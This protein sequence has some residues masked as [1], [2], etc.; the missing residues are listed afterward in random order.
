MRASNWR[1]VMFMVAVSRDGSRQRGN[2][3]NESEHL[4]EADSAGWDEQKEKEEEEG[5]AEKKTRNPMIE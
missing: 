3:S 5:A 2:R 1:L 4:V